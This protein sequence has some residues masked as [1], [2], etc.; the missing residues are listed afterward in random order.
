MIELVV[1][2]VRDETEGNDDCIR[3]SK[4]ASNFLVC[5]SLLMNATDPSRLRTMAT[6]SHHGVLRF[7]QDIFTLIALDS[8]PFDSV[9]VS[10]PLAPSM[11]FNVRAGTLE[12][13]RETL[14]RLVDTS[15]THWPEEHV[16]PSAGVKRR[17]T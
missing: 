4:S 1:H 2:F 17:R 10:C 8:I 16:E 5:S 7:L 11:A 14:T 15:L 3:I 12:K 13:G 6:M 9:Q